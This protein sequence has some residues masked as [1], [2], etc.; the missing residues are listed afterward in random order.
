MSKVT[1]WTWEEIAA[2]CGRDRMEFLADYG[3]RAKVA[4]VVATELDENSCWCGWP[5]VGCP[6]STKHLPTEWSRAVGLH[7]LCPDN[8]IP[9]YTMMIKKL[10][11]FPER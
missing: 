11:L 10:G 4:I 5:C 9:I 1:P 7:I 2:L 6:M 8:A 3:D